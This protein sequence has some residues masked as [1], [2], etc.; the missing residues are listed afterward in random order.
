[1]RV[2]RPVAA[3]A[4]ITTV[5]ALLGCEK[6]RTTITVYPDGSGKIELHDT[7]G[8]QLAGFALM[9]ADSPEKKQQAAESTIQKKLAGWEGVCAWTGVK[10]AVTEGEE[11]DGEAT[12]Y[13]EDVTK[14][15]RVEEKNHTSF[16]FT[17]NADGG[18][19]LEQVDTEVK[20]DDAGPA[21]KD[22]SDNFLKK[23][24]EEEMNMAVTM[25]TG[26]LQGLLI[27]RSIVMPGEVTEIKGAQKK[28]GRKATFTVS[29][30]EIGDLIKKAYARGAELRKQIDE[31]KT[32]EE[33]AK[34]ELDG[35][36]KDAMKAVKV[37]SK[38]GDSDAE[39]KENRKA[40]E[41]AKKEFAGSELEKKIE[42][43]KKQAA[44]MKKMFGPKK[45]SEKPGNPGDDDDKGMGKD[46]DKDE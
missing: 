40:L 33:K 20:G 6:E 2:R 15:K 8:K 11:I 24:P 39:A 3:L 25:T 10:G 29:D 45:D 14:L 36:F 31:G 46:K 22:P 41:A 28:D 34:A 35:E 19:T 16:K 43:T 18:F 5:L 42:E 17:K 27:E 26:M 30:K 9:M 44:D 12:G 13:F 23:M 38:A 4:T 21:K 7:L 32:T 1:M 37:T